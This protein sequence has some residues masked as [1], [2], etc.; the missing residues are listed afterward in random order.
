[1]F[2]PDVVTEE[3]A[4]LARTV[5]RFL[6]S[7]ADPTSE[8]LSFDSVLWAEL[9]EQFGLAGALIP[10]NLGGFGFGPGEIVILQKEFGRSL[11]PVPFLSTGVL[12]AKLL[13]ESDDNEARRDAI[14]RIVEDREIAAVALWTEVGAWAELGK[15]VRAKEDGD[16]WILDGESWYVTDGMAASLIVV[17]ADLNGVPAIFTVDANAAGVAREELVTL[18]LTRPQALIRFAGSKARMVTTPERAQTAV[19]HTLAIA[20]L[21][22]T[23]EQVGGAEAIMSMVVDYAK[24]RVQFG[25]PIG[26]FQ[27]IKHKLADM[28]LELERMKSA[29]NELLTSLER[30]EG[31]NS[32]A[33]L[34]KVYASE[35]YFR[36]AAENIQVHGGI[37]FT[38]EHPAHLYFR[39]AK[40][41]EFIFGSPSEHRDLMLQALEV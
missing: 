17:V 39:R 22:L 5:R 9:V 11:V 41:D 20:I 21:A 15:S 30:E 36:L 40:S 2:I 14:T 4:D 6:D 7:R 23:A 31:L 29:L 10:E 8:A 13:V 25:R 34:A 19:E 26:G 35:A 12:A 18:D 37:G 3:Q 24:T 1:V 38:W 27:A 28:A 32:L 33:H 16:Q